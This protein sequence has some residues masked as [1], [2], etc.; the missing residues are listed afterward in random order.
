LRRLH[1]Q[2]ILQTHNVP[3]R[4]RPA[5]ELYFLEHRP[6]LTEER[7]ELSPEQIEKHLHGTWMNESYAIRGLYDKK[8]VHDKARYK[9]DQLEYWHLLL[10][11]LEC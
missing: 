4:P 3:R 1:Q 9:L 8:K 11:L 5:R 7:P 6:R 2:R 10:E